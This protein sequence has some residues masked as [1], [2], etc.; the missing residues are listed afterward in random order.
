MLPITQKQP[1]LFDWP[2][3]AARAAGRDVCASRHRGN[4]ESEAAFQ[5]LAPKLSA[6]QNEVFCV[7]ELEGPRGLTCKEA[8]EKLAVGMNAISGRFTELKKAGR[9]KPTG[10]RRDG[11][12][13]Y[14]V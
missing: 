2:S 3:K 1:S 6:A 10:E 9:I 12:A 8:A 13:A 7:I 11:G 4:A 14:R 5:R